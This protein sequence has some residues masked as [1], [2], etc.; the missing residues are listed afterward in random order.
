MKSGIQVAIVVSIITPKDEF[1]L[2]MLLSK[3]AQDRDKG[4][5]RYQTMKF[6]VQGPKS[7]T[8]KIIGKHENVQKSA[9]VL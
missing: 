8:Q 3:S 7:H 1:V 5:P 2:H 6:S 4:D 9:E